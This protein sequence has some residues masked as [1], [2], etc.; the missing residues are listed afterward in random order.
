M[1]SWPYGS[2]NTHRLGT[3]GVA[4]TDYHNWENRY[5]GINQATIFMENVDNCIE[6]NEQQRRIMK[7]EARFF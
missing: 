1:W 2:W 7:A 6:L 3:W 4:N 5:V